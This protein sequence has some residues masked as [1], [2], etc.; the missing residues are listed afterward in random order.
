[1]GFRPAEFSNCARFNSALSSDFLELYE[2]CID[3][4][5]QTKSMQPK[6]KSFAP[7]SSR[8]KRVS[9]FRLR[10]VQPDKVSKPDR[11]LQFTAD[12]GTACHEIIQKRLI[13]KFR[14][15]W[16]DVAEYVKQKGF[17]YTVTKTGLESQV[18]CT[19]IPVRFACDGLIRY[20]GKIRLLEIKSSDHASFSDMSGPKL[21]HIDQVIFYCERLDLDDVL[22]LYIDRQ[23]GDV[24]C[25]E[26]S[27]SIPQKDAVKD[28]CQFVID[29]VDANIAPDG[30]PKGDP[31][32]TPDMCPYYEKCKEW[33]R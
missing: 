12:I 28:T 21:K 22:F 30:L 4:E 6:H 33:G 5:I 14:E 7:S 3:E 29:M 31:D 13:S 19:D 23:Y 2:S 9:W 25:F 11:G 15:D 10:G 16:I 1:M 26:L 24:K 27:V 17:N 18:E 8:C 20:K 32:C